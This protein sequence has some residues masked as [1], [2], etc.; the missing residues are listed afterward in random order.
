MIKTI[1]LSNGITMPRI[2]LGVW[3]IDNS[4][5][6]QVIKWALEAGYRHIDTAEAYMNEEGVGKG[7]RESGIPRS[8]IFVTSKLMIQ[9]FFWAEKSF[10]ESLRKLDLDYIDLFLL[11]RAF[12][13][14]KLAWKVLE[15]QYKEGKIKSIG[16]SNFGIKELK[17]MKKM[18][19]ILPMVNQVELSPFLNRQKLVDYCR[20]EGIV[21]EAYSPLTRGKRLREAILIEL[22]LKYKKSVA[23]IMIRWGLQKDLVVLPKS[24]NKDHI[25]SNFEVFDFE[26]DELDIKKLDGMDENFS[27]LPG[28]S[29][30]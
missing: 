12:L 29:K 26:I 25:E 13:G 6:S 17:E 2:G 11:H 22:A 9:N 4:K 5:V 20:E 27:T 24:E 10:K 8:E 28:W 21:V 23:Q 18:G 19:E 30:G 3:K 1:Q 15:K 16:V 7:I 14:W